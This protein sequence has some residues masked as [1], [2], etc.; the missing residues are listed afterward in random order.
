LSGE[1][2][3]PVE[4][5]VMHERFKRIL[6]R[7]EHVVFVAE[8]TEV[9]GWIH[10]AEQQMLEFDVRCEILG[11]VVGAAQRGQGVGRRLVEAVEDW[12]RTRSLLTFQSA[13]T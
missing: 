11:L 10:G 12:A 5:R 6:D 4:A 9:V 13:A 1:L 3:Y 8:T 7:G 2:G